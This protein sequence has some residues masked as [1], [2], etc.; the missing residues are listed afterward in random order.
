MM[1]IYLFPQTQVML[2]FLAGTINMEDGKLE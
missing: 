1:K 2:W